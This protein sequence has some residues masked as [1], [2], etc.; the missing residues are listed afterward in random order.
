MARMTKAAQAERAEAIAQL[1]EWLKPG[2]TVYCVLRNRSRS[3]MSREIGLVIMKDGSDLHPNYSVAKAL[4]E[5][6]GKHDGIIMGGCGMDMGFALVYHLSHILFPEGF[7]IVPE[8]GPDSLRPMSR[9]EA[10]KMVA[11]GFKFRG[12]NGDTSGWDNDGGYALKHRW[13]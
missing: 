12:R 2:D 3:G 13:L 10:A 8:G 9:D 5:R 7:G 11:Q 4:G 6:Q 1:R